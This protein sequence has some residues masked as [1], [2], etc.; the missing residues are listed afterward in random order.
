LP[1]VGSTSALK[2]HNLPGQ[3]IPAKLGGRAGAVRARSR[4]VTQVGWR[5]NR[6]SPRR[7][8]RSSFR[9]VARASHCDIRTGAQG[10]G[11]GQAWPFR[12]QKKRVSAPGSCLAACRG[13]RVLQ[14]PGLTRGTHPHSALLRRLRP[15]PKRYGAAHAIAIGR[16]QFAFVVGQAGNDVGAHGTQAA[17]KF[18]G[19]EQVVRRA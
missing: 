11:R 8:L 5:S 1:S 3:A 16:P 19:R 13:A 15:V 2:T 7:R 14:I 9:H 17:L 12:S 6:K 10:A 4:D 18:A